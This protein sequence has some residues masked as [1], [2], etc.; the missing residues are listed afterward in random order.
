MP[1]LYFYFYTNSLHKH[2]LNIK[3]IYLV[4]A[5]S[6]LYYKYI[7]ALRMCGKACHYDNDIFS[8]HARSVY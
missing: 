4:I 2:W 7:F 1:F 6:V 3:H 8:L 5:D